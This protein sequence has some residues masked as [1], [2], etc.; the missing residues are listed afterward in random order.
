MILGIDPGLR[1]TG[2]GLVRRTASGI[3]AVEFG[4][5]K[6]TATNP[7]ADRLYEIIS[8]LSEIIEQYG[9]TIASVE[10]I[11][12]SVNAKSALLLGHIRGAILTELRRNDIKV[13]EYTPLAIKQALVGYGRAEKSQVA[14]MCKLL[15]GLK[16]DIKPLDASDALAAAIC[17]INSLPPYVENE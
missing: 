8:L 2:Y 4:V 11:F 16:E 12:Y 1:V 10:Q 15:L 5:V 17:H 14:E 13:F 6:S 3:S 9:P 7:L